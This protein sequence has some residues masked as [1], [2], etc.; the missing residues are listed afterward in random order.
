MRKLVMVLAFALL[1]GCVSS[2][3]LY[4]PNTELPYYGRGDQGAFNRAF[5]NG[6]EHNRSGILMTWYNTRTNNF[7]TV[8]P[9]PAFNH[10]NG[11]IC[12][13]FQSQ[14]T[15]P[16]QGKEFN[17]VGVGCREPEFGIWYV[18][19]EDGEFASVK[20]TDDPRFSINGGNSNGWFGV[21]GH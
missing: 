21:N 17:S 7:G 14:F 19:L 13:K 1:T 5:Q 18:M 4:A 12:R 15:S 3:P 20:Y 8:T 2:P 9:R 10:Q 16:R 11:L 6:M